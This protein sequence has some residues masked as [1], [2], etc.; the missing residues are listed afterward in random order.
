MNAL[1]VGVLAGLM[2][3]NVHAADAKK[4]EPKKEQ[5]A[6]TA[7]APKTKKVCKDVTG[8]DGKPVMDTKTNKPKQECRTVKIHEKLEGTKVPEKK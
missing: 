2:A 4:E 5:P 1:L 8:K 3:F 6:A 7:E